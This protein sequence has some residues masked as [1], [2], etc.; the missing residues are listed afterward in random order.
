MDRLAAPA[1]AAR[2]ELVARIF[3]ACDADGD[4]WS[5]M[6]EG[7]C[8]VDTDNDGTPDYLDTDDDNPYS[9]LNIFDRRLFTM[10]K[11]LEKVS[12]SNNKYLFRLS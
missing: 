10:N 5:D 1:P 3:A 8:T 9:K 11:I 7:D 6:V 4:G 12:L 2:G